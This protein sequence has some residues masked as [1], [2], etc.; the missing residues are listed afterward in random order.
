MQG[1]SIGSPCQPQNVISGAAVAKI[2]TKEPIPCKPAPE[3]WLRLATA[4]A[5]HR[6]AVS[7]QPL[8]REHPQASVNWQECSSCRGRISEGDEVQIIISINQGKCVA[9]VVKE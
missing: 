4:A 1:H 8:Q 9:R 3:R 7:S 6:L 5:A 2:S